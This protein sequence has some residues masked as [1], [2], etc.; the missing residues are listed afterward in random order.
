MQISSVTF[1]KSA[2]KLSECPSSNFPEIAVI[3]RSNVGKSS[4]INFLMDKTIAKASDKPWKTQLI[5][6]FLV[7]ES[8][9]F[10]DLPWYGYAK[11]SLEQRR[12]WIDEIHGYFLQRKP[13]ILLLIDGSLPPQKIDL[14]F[15]S[16]LREESLNFALIL[17]KTD[18][19]NQKTLHQNI[20]LLKQALQKEMWKVPELLLSSTIKK[21]GKEQILAFINQQVLG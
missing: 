15:I 11:V 9:Y 13:F 12:K 8:R 18:K 4:L 3:G 2:S 14:E 21:Q 20:K 16:A 6:Y 5:N 1:V 10:V 7:N 17:T 19:A